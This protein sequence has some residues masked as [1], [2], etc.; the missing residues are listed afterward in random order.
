MSEPRRV[1]IPLLPGTPPEL[2]VFDQVTPCPYLPDTIARMPLRLPTRNLTRAELG[3]RLA[4]G[5]RRQGVLLYRTRCPACEACQPIRI[6]VARFEPSRTH[7]RVLARAAREVSVTRGPPIADEARVD[8]YNAHKRGRG[9]G[10]GQRPIDLEGYRE[11]LVSSC[12]E[13]FELAYRVGDELA[14]VAIV[15]RATDGLSAV[16]CHYDVRFGDLAIGTFSVLHQIELCR[17][18]GLRWLYLGLY[19][20]GSPVMA[21]KARYRP[22]ERLIDGAWRAFERGDD[23]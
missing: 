17:A 20:V 13:S 4:E 14:G 12:G 18:W 8:L 5:D 16:Y 3:V 10:D 1:A 6:D 21:Y 2:V 23:A 15:D 9:L 22:H 19:V 11:F 7:R